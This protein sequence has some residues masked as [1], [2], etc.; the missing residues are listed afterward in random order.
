MFRTEQDTDLVLQLVKMYALVSSKY[1][2]KQKHS[3]N[4]RTLTNQDVFYIYIHICG[5]IN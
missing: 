4:M 5:F 2:H 1:F 3:N